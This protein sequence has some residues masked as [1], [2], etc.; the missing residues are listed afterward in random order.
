ML[1][2]FC[3]DGNYVCIRMFTNNDRVEKYYDIFKECYQQQMTTGVCNFSIILKK[4]YM[5][6]KYCE[7]YINLLRNMVTK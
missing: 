3:D 1:T 6:L 2:I 5:V 7:V 4:L